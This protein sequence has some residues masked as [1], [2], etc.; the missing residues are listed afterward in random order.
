[1]IKLNQPLLTFW[2]FRVFTVVE[3]REREEGFMKAT[4]EKVIKVSNY[5][6]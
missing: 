2:I 3:R 4:I 1:M 5:F 6:M